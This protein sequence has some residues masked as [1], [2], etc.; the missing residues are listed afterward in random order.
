[1]D[2][3]RVEESQDKAH[4]V[5]VWTH[6]QGGLGDIASASKMIN[7]LVDYSVTFDIYW[8]LDA[9]PDKIKMAKSMLSEKA[10]SIVKG[11]RSWYEE[12]FE[13]TIHLVIQ[14]P[15]LCHWNMSYLGNKLGLNLALAKTI[16]IAEAG[17]K[18]SPNYLSLGLDPDCDGVLL[19][20]A[21]Q[22]ASLQ[23]L[24]DC[25]LSDV[26]VEPSESASLNFG[27]AHHALSRLNF[28]DCVV[29]HDTNSP[30]IQ[31]VL[32]QKG[33]FECEEETS[34]AETL[35]SCQKRRDLL[36]ANAIKE[37]QI[38]ASLHSAIIFN[39]EGDADKPLDA[40]NSTAKKRTL[41][42]ILRHSFAYN[43]MRVLQTLADR[44]L[45][46]GNNSAFQA[47]SY[48]TRCQLYLY[49]DVANAGVT[50][51]FLLQQ[52]DSAKI[53]SPVVAQLLQLFGMRKNDGADEL[54]IIQ[55]KNR[56]QAIC[57][58]LG[59]LSN[60]ESDST[61]LWFEHVRESNQNLFQ[62]RFFAAIANQMQKNTY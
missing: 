38:I 37:V 22:I 16:A 45:V 5:L 10:H 33:E 6:V 42:I 31:I 62:K 28:V 18:P 27:Y 47:W 26:L 36:K 50:W 20:D 21:F 55:D 14:T 61:R 46:T 57:E 51:R 58:Q 8:V 43:D 32:N 29:A 2:D 12:P 3:T 30:L 60:N 23:N 59:L 39:L 19:E 11:L 15:C 56:W 25:T 34:F 48:N 35:L 17:T 53:C 52:I 4:N 13:P 7:L 44:L 41:R 49:E 54:P 40:D 9:C 1:M 24:Q